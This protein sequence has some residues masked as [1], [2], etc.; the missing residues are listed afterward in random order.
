MIDNVLAIDLG[1][2]NGRVFRIGLKNQRLYLE[3]VY[4]FANGGISIHERCYTDI[5]NLYQQIIKGIR[6]AWKQGP[7]LSLAVDTWGVDFG[8]LD[9]N[10]ELIGNP[11]FYRDSQSRGMIDEANAFFGKMGLFRKTGVQDMWYNTVY[12]IQ[13]MNKRK[14]MKLKS[15]KS[16]LMLPDL[17]A[18][19]LTGEKNLEYT[20][21]STT[22]MVD[23]RTGQWDKEIL[24]KL[25]MDES[26]FAPILETGKIKGY[27]T[28]VV[29]AEA[30]IPE[31]IEIP[32]I[33]CAEHD[34]ASAACVIP[35]KSEG[36]LYINS[37]TWSIIGQILD[38]PI[39]TEQVFLEGM[40]NEGAAYGKIKL[41]K[42]IMGMWFIQQL[43]KDWDKD[44]KNTAYDYL[45]REASKERPFEHMID[46]ED[47]SFVSPVSMEK[48]IQ[49]YCKR[50]G[51]PK[52]IR[53]GQYY[54]AVR[55][56]LAFQYR[57]AIKSLEQITGKEAECVHL[58]G[59]ASQDSTFC[60]Y[61]ANATGKT[62]LAGPVEATAIGNAMVQ[63]RTMS[64]MEEGTDWNQILVD[65]FQ[66]E[67]YEPKN[68]EVWDQKYK[69]YQTLL[70]KKMN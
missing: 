24:Q 47:E 14:C 20:E 51:Q 11:F 5:L 16:F 9:Q 54:R 50:T 39:I 60:Q 69:Q 67:T 25:N 26:M 37:G 35:Q 3:E 57:R 29:K 49:D 4:R 19:L 13:G 28:S 48:A 40:S 15:A 70:S 45:E 58:L 34:S 68:T 46:T 10:G 55:E 52:I 63:I 2:S 38:K 17:L 53:Q 65:S 44:N 1:A 33:A 30:G 61:I 7:F 62:V 18:Y 42:S 41:V 32:L 23:M 36:C 22:Q 8:L 66:I 27:L 21:V 64:L 56:S 43:R 6:I 31:E 12:Q 59:G